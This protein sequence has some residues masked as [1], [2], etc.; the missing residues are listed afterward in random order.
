MA[1]PLKIMTPAAQTVTSGMTKATVTFRPEF[2]AQRT[3]MFA[4]TQ[5]VIDAAVLRYNSAYV[6]L[7]DG[8][9]ERSGTVGTVI[10]DGEV[11]YTVPY[12]ARHYYNPQYN[13]NEAPQRGAYHF[14]RMKADHKD[15]IL[16]A[17]KKEAGAK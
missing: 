7:R 6:P 3:E 2:G 5:C 10:G 14:E 17:A 15:D 1:A 12:A 8:F 11:N 4:R 13:F 16:I 9:Y